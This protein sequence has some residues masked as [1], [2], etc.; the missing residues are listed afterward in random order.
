MRED[1]ST[2]ELLQD[3]AYHR[4]FETDAEAARA[5]TDDDVRDDAEEGDG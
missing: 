4:L 2:E 5:D 3:A 1:M